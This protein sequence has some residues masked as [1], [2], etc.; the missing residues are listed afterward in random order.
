MKT[1]RT[2]LLGA[3]LSLPL[4]AATGHAQTVI[5]ENGRTIT[6]PPGAVVLILPG[7]QGVAASP[8]TVAAMRQNVPMLR[9]IAQQQAMMRHMLAQMS[10]MFPPMPP[11]PDPSQMFRAAF[12]AGGPM[13]TL[14]AGP[15]V[16][17]E[18]ISI[19]Q[20]GNSPP[21]ITHTSSGCGAH[22]GGHPAAVRDLPPAPATPERTPNL[23]R[24]EYPP[25]TN[26]VLA[27]TVIAE[28]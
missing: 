14:A 2:A 22:A 27:G 25:H 9:M 21:V 6:V 26:A 28:R 13:V 16:C 17:S 10:A 11:M 1:I 4:L 12:G 19:I 3:C 15:G 5:R 23:L 20:H 24:V 8:A 7:P 18:S